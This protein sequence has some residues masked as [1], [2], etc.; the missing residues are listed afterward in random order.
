MPLAAKGQASQ[1]E[2]DA[3]R[4]LHSF[5]GNCQSSFSWHWKTQKKDDVSLLEG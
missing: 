4:L 1:R 2:G 3:W 5:S